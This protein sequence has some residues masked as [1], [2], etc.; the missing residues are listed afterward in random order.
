MQMWQP[1][2]EL[3]LHHAPMAGPLGSELLLGCSRGLPL[4]TWR[5]PLPWFWSAKDRV[6]LGSISWQSGFPLFILGHFFHLDMGLGLDIKWV[7]VPRSFGPAVTI[8][9]IL[10]IVFSHKKKGSLFLSPSLS[11]SKFFGRFFYFF[12]HLYFRLIIFYIL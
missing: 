11:L 7:G 3:L 12:L 8:S 10:C 4:A 2:L 9:S 5:F 1:L 6:V